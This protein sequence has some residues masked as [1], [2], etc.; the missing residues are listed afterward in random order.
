V[1]E[2]FNVTFIFHI[3]HLTLFSKA[4]PDW[5]AS[6]RR[7]PLGIIG[8]VFTSGRPTNNVTDAISK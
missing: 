1:L 6:H 7:K 3:V 2:T 5:A 4:A 8:A